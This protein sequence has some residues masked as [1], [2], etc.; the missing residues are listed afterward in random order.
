MSKEFVDSLVSVL[1]P[2]IRGK[3]IGVERPDA[4]LSLADATPQFGV[5]IAKPAVGID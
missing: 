1:S 5:F 3:Q 4:A 2:L